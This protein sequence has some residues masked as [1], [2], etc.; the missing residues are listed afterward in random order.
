M[1]LTDS[2]AS[3]SNKSDSS[4]SNKLI[5]IKLVATCYEHPVSAFPVQ[6]ENLADFSELK[7]YVNL[8]LHAQLQC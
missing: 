2:G 3:C 1:R 8:P 7:L 5:T 4:V 6:S